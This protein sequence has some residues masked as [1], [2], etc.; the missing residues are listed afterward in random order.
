M[1]SFIILLS[2]LFK[3]DGNP[4][5]CTIYNSVDD[6]CE[7]CN[8]GRFLSFGICL[9]EC[10]TGYTV[11]NSDCVQSSSSLKIIETN[12]YETASI[13]GNSIGDFKTTTNDFSDITISLVPTDNRGFY[14][15]ITSNLISTSTFYLNPY[16]TIKLYVRP[17]GLGKILEIESFLIISVTSFRISSS[18]R[19]IKQSN[20]NEIMASITGSIILGE[21]IRVLI[22][23]S[24]TTSTILNGKMF[25]NDIST[26]TSHSGYEIGE[27]VSSNIFIGDVYNSGTAE[28]F[29][30]KIEIWN[31]IELQTYADLGLSI[32]DFTEYLDGNNCIA[33]QSP[34]TVCRRATDCSICYFIECSN[35]DGYGKEQCSSCTNGEASPY[36]CDYL[37]ES[38]INRGQCSTC[39]TGT[40]LTFD[41]CVSNLPTGFISSIDTPLVV[42]SVNFMENNFSNYYAPLISSML[43]KKSRGRGVY[44]NGNSYLSSE[45][46]IV[47]AAS[48]SIQILLK[49]VSSLSRNPII[50]V[51][52]ALKLFT[53]DPV[54]EITTN[55]Y[56]NSTVTSSL[57]APIPT[58]AWLYLTIT[59]Y[60]SSQS[61][62]V[63]IYSNSGQIGMLTVP[64]FLRMSEA[65]FILGLDESNFF[66]GFIYSFEFY[67]GLIDLSTAIVNYC[68]SGVLTGCVEDCSFTSYYED[69]L[70]YMC[71][72]SCTEGCVKGTDCSLC[73]ET[74]GL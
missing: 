40:F 7:E 4:T 24:S 42:L 37:C 52:G 55:D 26:S 68:Q 22:T 39:Q 57:D 53:L 33:C 17:T 63:S 69:F 23:C 36:C 29:Y 62:S 54:I 3:A 34:C 16:F 41:I 50:V 30:Y 56:M 71:L 64:G 12:F 18:L 65:V 70:C 8:Q 72:S 73:Y 58:L 48:F 25:I 44:F 27:T 61:T 6:M 15:Q 14:G 20:L 35:C 2:S 51:L 32:C 5:F 38:C 21:W 10:P 66:N 28:G 74:R 9:P 19:V 31:E 13:Y 11:F 45:N 47:L 43:P 59:A 67:I 46:T 49:I 60:P 1:L